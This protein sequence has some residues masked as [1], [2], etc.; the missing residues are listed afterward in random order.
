MNIE[1]KK[2][3]NYPKYAVALAAIASAAILTGCRTAGVVETGGDVPVPIYEDDADTA[4]Q[5]VFAG[6]EMGVPT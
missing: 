2:N 3:A 1:P 6:D 5:T 4:E